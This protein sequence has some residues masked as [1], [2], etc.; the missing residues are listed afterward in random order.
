M[1]YRHNGWLDESWR[2]QTLHLRNP[3]GNDKRGLKG[4]LRGVLGVVKEAPIN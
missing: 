4:S 1:E 2:R 3:E